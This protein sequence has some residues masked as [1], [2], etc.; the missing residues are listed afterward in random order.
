MRAH[1]LRI[2]IWIAV[3]EGVLVV[4]DV[5]SG[6]VALAVAAAVI[7]FYVHVGRGLRADVSRQVAWTA[8]LSQM[9]VAL[10]PVLVFVV[11]AVALVAVG[12]LAVLG[13][14]ALLADRR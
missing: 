3:L 8:A 9:L 5:I 11:G 6:W 14:V 4:F 13:V 1:R 2:A 7:A 12:I 10:V